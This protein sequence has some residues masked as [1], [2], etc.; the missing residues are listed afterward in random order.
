MDF[1][2]LDEGLKTGCVTSLGLNEY[3]YHHTL[4]V[5]NVRNYGYDV[6]GDRPWAKEWTLTKAARTLGFGPVQCADFVV[7]AV[8]GDD[9]ELT[10]YQIVKDRSGTGQH[11]VFEILRGLGYN[12]ATPKTGLY[13]LDRQARRALRT[14]F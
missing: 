1:E 12:V 6:G 11:V 4:F 13:V 8:A 5:H 14:M 3:G 7:L 10:T 2:R 9:A